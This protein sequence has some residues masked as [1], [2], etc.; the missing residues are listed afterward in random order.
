MLNYFC[1]YNVNKY[2]NCIQVIEIFIRLNFWQLF[3]AIN[4]SE[5][6]SQRRTFSTGYKI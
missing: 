3:C 1:S 5:Y 2:Y 4:I 6:L